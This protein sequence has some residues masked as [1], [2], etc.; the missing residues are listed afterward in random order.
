MKIEAILFD[1]DGTLWDPCEAVCTAW[2]AVAIKQRLFSLYFTPEVIRSICGSTPEQFGPF[3]LPKLSNAARNHFLTE[4]MKAEV[5]AVEGVASRC[6]YPG[7]A[8]GLLR[9]REYVSLHVVSNCQSEYLDCFLEKSGIGSLF[10]SAVCHGGTGLDKADN[11]LELMERENIGDAI[12]VGDTENDERAASSAG[13]PFIHA[14]YGFGR[15]R[16]CALSFPNFD[17]LTTYLLGH[18]ETKLVV[19]G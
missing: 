12:Y 14:G 6:L 5:L 8:Q 15:A 17:R 18:L 10:D 4:A 1:L 13:I 16:T 19:N 9:L 2:N 3:L 7:V 11:I